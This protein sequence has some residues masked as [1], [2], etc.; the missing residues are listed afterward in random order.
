MRGITARRA[1]RSGGTEIRHRVADKG[2]DLCRRV[3]GLVLLHAGNMAASVRAGEGLK[4]GGIAINAVFIQSWILL[5]S[6]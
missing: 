3:G 5:I 4:L 2:P 1:G 6:R